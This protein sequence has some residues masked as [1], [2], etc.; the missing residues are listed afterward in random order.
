M[1]RASLSLLLV[2]AIAVPA[3]AQSLVEVPVSSRNPAGVTV[4]FETASGSPPPG[5]LSGTD[6]YLLT[7]G[8]ANVSLVNQP[9]TWTAGSDVLSGGSSPLTNTL[10][11]VNGQLAIVAPGGALDDPGAGA[12]WSFQFQGQVSQF[13]FVIEDQA[14]ISI[15]VEAY[16]GGSLV[17][18]LPGVAV[19]AGFPNT[20]HTFD[21]LV[22]CDEIRV[23]SSTSTGGFGLDNLFIVSSGGG[24][25]V[26]DY[27]VNSDL[28]SLRI[29][30]SQGSE[31]FPFVTSRD[32]FPACGPGAVSVEFALSSDSPGTLY[33]LAVSTGPS[34]GVSGGGFQ[35]P[36][37]RI[38]FDLLQP[39]TFVASGARCRS[40]CPCR[41][42][43]FPA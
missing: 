4:D 1:H 10:C 14:G 2:L 6:P 31:F 41:E 37:L 5:P 43:A 34:V 36:G 12:G 18:S 20:P 17:A 26:P 16:L 40:S 29:D 21:V 22:P 3:I 42:G 11:S 15:D 7:F 25:L 9:G 38:N 8:L 28:L 33:D 27:Q 23:L 35:I 24:P 30:G 19:P 13:G 39:Y 32:V